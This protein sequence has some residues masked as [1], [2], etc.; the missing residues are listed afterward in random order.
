MGWGSVLITTPLL[1][2]ITDD[3]LLV[4]DF[5]IKS[6]AQWD[7]DGLFFAHVESSL[8]PDEGSHYDVGLRDGQVVFRRHD[9][10]T[11]EFS[12]PDP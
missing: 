10:F 5:K 2:R 6:Q 7:H 12:P 8:I 3:P 1:T 4:S 11:P 9:E